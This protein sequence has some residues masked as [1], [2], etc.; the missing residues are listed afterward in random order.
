MRNPTH[1]RRTL[2]LASAIAMAIAACAPQTADRLPDGAFPIVANADLAVGAQ[3]V[4][5]GLV[6]PDAVS[7]ASPDLAVEI[8][9]YPP[10]VDEPTI[11]TAGTFAWT[12]PDVRGLYYT[13]VDFVRAGNWQVAVHTGGGHTGT[14]VSFNV[15]E[16]GLTPA[17][18]SMAPAAATPTLDTAQLEDITTDPNPDSRFYQISLDVALG[19]GR[20]TVLVFSTPAF[21]ETATCG[22]MLDAVKE[23]ARGYPD[24]NFIHVE[25]YE[26][27]DAT[28]RDELQ[29]APAVAL[30]RLPS[31]PWTFIIDSAGNIAS[32]FEGTITTSELTAALA[33]LD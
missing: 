13:N 17:V 12:V 31:E 5:I 2:L 30:W 10:E 14:R 18:G 1:T 22:P 23:T 11:A 8:D 24:V 27:L 29:L 20:P 33:N 25:V 16:Q 21:C 28:T 7:V 3:R 19:S 15:A 32:K 4:L 26:N 6:T 9:F